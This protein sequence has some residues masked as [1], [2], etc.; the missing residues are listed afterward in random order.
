MGLVH[1]AL[2]FLASVIGEVNVQEVVPVV[3]LLLIMYTVFFLFLLPECLHSFCGLLFTYV[4]R[5]RPLH[6]TSDPVTGVV[7]ARAVPVFM[8]DGPLLSCSGRGNR[9][10]VVF[11]ACHRAWESTAYDLLWSILHDNF[12]HFH[13]FSEI[14]LYLVRILP[15]YNFDTFVACTWTPISLCLF[16]RNARNLNY[17]L[18]V[19]VFHVRERPSSST[20][21]SCSSYLLSQLFQTSVC[22][23][24]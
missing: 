21:F 18:S 23:Q 11:P 16:S 12:H 8:H 2:L 20:S 15:R 3:K 14:S 7:L 22:A 10:I 24:A 13:P 6:A 9:L 1:H 17:V 19:E 5:C 4:S